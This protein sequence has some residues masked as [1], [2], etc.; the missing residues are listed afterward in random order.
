MIKKLCKKEGCYR[1]DIHAKRICSK[2][3]QQKYRLGEIITG[4]SIFTPNEF[5]IEKDICKIRLFNQRGVFI[6]NA[7]IDIEDYDRCKNHKWGLKGTY[8]VTRIDNKQIKLHH[9]IIGKPPLGF[10]VDHLNRNTLDYIKINLRFAT[11]SQNNQNK[12][13][14]NRSSK[15]KGVSTYSPTNKWR[16]VITVNDKII[17]LGLYF[18][19]IS[20]AKAYDKAALKYFGKYACTNEMLGLY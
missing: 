4:C 17:S 20:A 13:G 10:V 14:S 9:F 16:A 3:Y 11:Y 6:N 8:V 15:F 5:I 7:I 19:E 18:N 2:H 12:K 1:D